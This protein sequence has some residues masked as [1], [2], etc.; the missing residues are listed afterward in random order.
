MDSTLT[1]LC[2]LSFPFGSEFG[3][4]IAG[5]RERQFCFIKLWLDF[6]NHR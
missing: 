5:R 3:R 2:S 6:V 4:E 1:M